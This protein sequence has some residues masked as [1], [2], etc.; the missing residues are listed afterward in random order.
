MQ[1]YLFKVNGKQ[2][3]AQ[4]PLVN[5]RDIDNGLHKLVLDQI[6]DYDFVD[7]ISNLST[8]LKEL[9]SSFES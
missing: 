3:K 1:Q 7:G 2:M 6:I 4:A 5:F 9:K 8:F